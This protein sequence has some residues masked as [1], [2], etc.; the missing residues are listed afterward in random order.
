M[1]YILKKLQGYSNG[2]V[3]DFGTTNVSSE[4]KEKV[5]EII[6][7]WLEV[8]MDERILVGEFDSMRTIC[9]CLNYTQYRRI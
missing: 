4:E 8:E 1:L 2:R 6:F 7:H 3:I 9:G 5:Y